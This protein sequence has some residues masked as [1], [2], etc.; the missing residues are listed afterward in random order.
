[1]HQ[2]IE[3]GPKEVWSASDAAGV[4]RIQ[5][6]WQHP[7]LW[8]LNGKTPLLQGEY[9]IYQGGNQISIRKRW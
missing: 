8:T 5:L 4:R 9:K 7:E 1:M 2:W 3:K 6:M